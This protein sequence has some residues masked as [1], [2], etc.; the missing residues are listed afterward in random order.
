MS[1]TWTQLAHTAEAGATSISVIHGAV[2][3]AAGDVIV[4]A[5]S[6]T[7]M[8]ETEKMTI[9]SVTTGRSSGTGMG[10][11]KKDCPVFDHSVYYPTII[12]AS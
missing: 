9:A 2:S 8:H 6:T 12:C 3:W 11:V 10:G 5:S 4:I 7:D 1:P